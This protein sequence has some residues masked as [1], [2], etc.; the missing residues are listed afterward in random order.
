MS[1][2]LTVGSSTDVGLAAALWADRMCWDCMLT[3]GAEQ[4][5]QNSWQHTKGR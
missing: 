3:G 4:V 2:G 1:A 5:V